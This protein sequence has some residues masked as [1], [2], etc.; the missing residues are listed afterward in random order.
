MDVI[1]W[2]AVNAE[3]ISAGHVWFKYRD[4]SI[5]QKIHYVAI[6]LELIFKK[7]L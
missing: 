7:K 2:F 4:I 3:F 6:S 1:K 5:L